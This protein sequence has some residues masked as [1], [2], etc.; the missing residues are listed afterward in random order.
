MN[1][2][3]TRIADHLYAVKSLFYPNEP[4][5]PYVV[6]YMALGRIAVMFDSGLK[7]TAPD[8]L[9]LLAKLGRQPS[10]LRLILNS[11]AHHDHIGAN[12]PLKEA[13]GCMIL[14]EPSGVH[15]IE[16]HK[17]QHHEFFEAFPD[18]WMPS[19]EQTRDFF[20]WLGPETSV[21]IQPNG[22]FTLSLGDGVALDVFPT[23][24]HIS[25]CVSALDR[26]T[27]ALLTGD[28]FQAQGFFGNLPQYDS[29][30]GYT[31]S[32]F[33]YAEYVPRR[34]LTAHTPPVDEQD[35]P[36]QVAASSDMVREIGDT[37]RQVLRSRGGPVHLRDVGEAVCTRFRR[38]Y[39]IQA[40]CTVDAHLR[41]L[42]EDGQARRAEPGAN[43]W[44]G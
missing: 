10:D 19:A 44:L 41:G 24:G 16:D 11:H 35:A 38:T 30:A 39:S 31:S 4:D 2:D 1:S 8:V 5:G 15:W 7:S 26:G 21:E 32:L 6:S 9:D 25:S 23:P 20:E 29:V 14:A 36:S 37:V 43:I 40:L 33:T 3:V 27:N 42:E 22:A 12:G 13:T 28:S 17:R 18:A 34:V